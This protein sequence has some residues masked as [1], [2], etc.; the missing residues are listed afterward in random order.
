MGGGILACIAL[1]QF[2]VSLSTTYLAQLRTDIQ[3]LVSYQDRVVPY[4]TS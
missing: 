3:C 2:P 1:V 4:N